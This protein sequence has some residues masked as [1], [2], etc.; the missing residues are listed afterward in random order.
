[1]HVET[2]ENETLERI[3]QVTKCLLIYLERCEEVMADMERISALMN[4][5]MAVQLSGHLLFK[6]PGNCVGDALSAA[7][8][9]RNYMQEKGGDEGARSAKHLR[10]IR[11]QLRLDDIFGEAKHADRKTEVVTVC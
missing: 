1:M 9:L 2:F 8:A 10:A 3:D 5:D 11:R 6:V 7:C 4:T